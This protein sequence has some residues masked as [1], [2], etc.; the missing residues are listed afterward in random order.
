LA[1]EEL[2]TAGFILKS[3]SIKSII[4]FKTPVS[5]PSLRNAPVEHPQ[6]TVKEEQTVTHEK[7][8]SHKNLMKY[9]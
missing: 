1:L 4:S 5:K 7:A 3:S 8:N 2:S 9:W 6:G